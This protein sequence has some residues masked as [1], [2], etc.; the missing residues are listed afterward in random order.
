MSLEHARCHREDE[1]RR[2]R[3]Q[4]ERDDGDRVDLQELGERRGER[5]QGDRQRDGRERRQPECRA[6]EGSRPLAVAAGEA[7]R[8]LARDGQLQCAGGQEHDGEHPK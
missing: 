1:G 5:E 3:E 7:A 4:G 6:R 2:Q 8:K